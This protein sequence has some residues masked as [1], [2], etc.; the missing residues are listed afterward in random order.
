MGP[1]ITLTS[2]PLVRAMLSFF[3]LQTVALLAP[4]YG[5]LALVMP[6]PYL[7]NIVERWVFQDPETLQRVAREFGDPV[8]PWLSLLVI[9]GYCSLLIGAAALI[10]HRRDMAGS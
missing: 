7:P 1:A 4:L 10:F 8:S 2:R 5:S 9:V 3:G 6:Y